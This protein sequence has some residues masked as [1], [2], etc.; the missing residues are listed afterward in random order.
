[1]YVN[2]YIHYTC[3]LYIIHINQLC[4]LLKI[5]IDYAKQLHCVVTRGMYWLGVHNTQHSSHFLPV[6]HTFIPLMDFF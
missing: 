4:I 3:I 2:A 6:K 5:M 1:M